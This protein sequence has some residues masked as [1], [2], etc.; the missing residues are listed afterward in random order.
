MDFEQ[1]C[2]IGFGAYRI[3]VKSLE[4]E[5]ALRLALNEG[6]N[7]ID[8][9]ANY[10]D[11]GSEKLIGKVLKDYNRE[12]IFILTKGGYIQ[13]QN[14]ELLKKMQ[15]D[16]KLKTGVV[17]IGEDL[18]HSIEPEFL[19]EQIKLS[20]ERLETDHLDGYL[21][22][23]PEYYFKS[24]G[25]NQDEYYERIHRA[26]VYLE[27]QVEQGVIKY[28][29]ISSNNFPLSP[30]NPEVT[31]INRA[32]QC[33]RD[34][35]SDHHFKLVQ[36]PYNLIETGANEKQYG[37]QSLLDI[38]HENNLITFA[39]RPLNAFQDNQLLRL[40]TYPDQELT[41]KDGE[42][43]FEVCFDKLEDKWVENEEEIKDLYNIPLIKQFR[44]I[45]NTLPTPDAVDQVFQIYFFP[46]LAQVWGP[47]GVPPEEAKPFFL[48]Y[49]T[50][51]LFAR[52]RLSHKAA[53]IKKQMIK[54]GVFD[55]DDSRPLSQLACET[56]LNQG[57]DH[58]LVGMKK[59]NYVLD[60]K[61]LF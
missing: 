38:C 35:S 2:P 40:A 59:N 16:G 25:A 9:S 15:A 14:L 46:F 21:L 24:P 41:G 42:D 19:N 12:S 28:Y 37:Q 26:F 49:D 57:I 1:L 55:A 4:H 23:N 7:L 3:S 60:M 45:W 11:G 56:Y 58:V 29:G 50:A 44:E 34:V 17:E 61:P 52:R 53:Q 51:Q 8:T 43:I 18:K 22:H 54:E 13:G 39:N 47:T 31:N 36:F 20:L 30:E 27:E 48:L 10:T 6:C 5:E 33:A 32:L